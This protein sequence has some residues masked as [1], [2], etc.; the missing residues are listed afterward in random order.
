[1]VYTFEEKVIIRYVNQKFG[2]GA[3]KI[4]DDHPEYNWTISGVSGL[5]KKKLETLKENMDLDDHAL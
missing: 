4:V 5:L 1:M 3:R 2:H